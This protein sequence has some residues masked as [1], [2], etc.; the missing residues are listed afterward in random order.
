MS[1]YP[2]MRDPFGRC[3]L[4][5]Q[6]SLV[7]VPQKTQVAPVRFTVCLLGAP[8][9]VGSLGAP[10]LL[11]PTF[12][13]L[14]GGIPYLVSAGPAFWVALRSGYRA[15][16][17]FA[18]IGF[19]LNLIFTPLAALAAD[20]SG[21]MIGFMVLYGAVFAPIWSGVFAWLYRVNAPEKE[22]KP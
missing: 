8:V 19:V 12:A 20:P 13:V 2:I 11:V 7:P 17:A 1:V 18:L 22:V 10:L 16:Y 21:N 14:F 5:P 9:L 4:P 6:V 3:P 15:W